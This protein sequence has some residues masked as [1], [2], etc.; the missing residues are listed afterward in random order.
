MAAKDGFF[1]IAVLMD[2]LCEAVDV[3]NCVVN[4]NTDGDSG[5]GNG[6]DI[7][8]NAESSHQPK[9]KRGTHDVGDNTNQGHPERTK[10]KDKHEKDGKKNRTKGKDLG[11]VK[12]LEKII[13]Q[14]H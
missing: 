3:V 7:H 6:H 9:D 11:A 2:F 1:V 10:N 14:N 13:E 5:N 12:A 4:G 8:G